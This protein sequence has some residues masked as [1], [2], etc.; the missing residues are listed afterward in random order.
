MKISCKFTTFYREY[1]IIPS[2][3]LAIRSKTA[4]KRLAIFIWRAVVDDAQIAGI[5]RLADAP[6]TP[7]RLAAAKRQFL[8]QLVIS[9]ENRE[10]TLL[11][12][13]RAT[14]ISG[15]VTPM[16]D[17]I[18]AINDITA[19]DIARIAALLAEAPA[20]TLGPKK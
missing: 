15:R 10:N 6:M 19:A 5:A 7:R 4:L 20:L 3:L 16:A 12:A 13:A 17:A 1:E 14:L 9:N 2:N 18:A 8:G 11:S